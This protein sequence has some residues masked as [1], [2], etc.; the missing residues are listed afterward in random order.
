[1]KEIMRLAQ[2]HKLQVV[3]DCAHSVGGTYDGKTRMGGL[4]N[5]SCFSFYPT[6]NMTT[7][8]G[9]MITTNDDVLADRLRELRLHGLSKD[10]WKRYENNEWRYD[11]K[12][13]GFKYNMTDINA[14]LGLVQLG[15]LRVFCE[16]RKEIAERYRLLL[17]DCPIEFPISWDNK[18][19]HIYPIQ[20]DKRDGL[21][22]HLKRE[23]VGFSV[24][25]IPIHYHTA[26]Q[27]LGYKKGDFPVCEKF[28]ERT[29]SLPLYPELTDEQ[30]ERVGRVVHDFFVA[31]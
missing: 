18:V 16:R 27:Y 13:V 2:L 29:V 14:S 15:R 20:T 31:R 9:G 25:F 1:M 11:V 23:G 24:F 28:F 22:E 7:G 5:L 10:A 3:E 4:G 30:V 19:W 21:V 17:S 6:K 26:Y 12:S 8:E